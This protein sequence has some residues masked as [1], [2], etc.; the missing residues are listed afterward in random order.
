[1]LIL[2]HCLILAAFGGDIVS[3]IRPDIFKE[4]ERRIKAIGGLT[5][6]L[7]NGSALASARPHTPPGSAVAGSRRPGR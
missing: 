3:L 2:K 7:G 4:G 5:S 1:M 6:M